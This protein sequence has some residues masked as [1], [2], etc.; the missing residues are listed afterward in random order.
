M[1]FTSPTDFSSAQ[2]LRAWRPRQ[3]PEAEAY[4]CAGRG[5]E[6]TL[7]EDPFAVVLHSIPG[8]TSSGLDEIMAPRV[9]PLVTEMLLTSNTTES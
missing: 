7:P 1:L 5:P 6:R 3:H 8:R 4:S 9:P 2:G